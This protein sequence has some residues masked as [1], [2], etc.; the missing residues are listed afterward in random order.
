ME[1]VYDVHRLVGASLGDLWWW[2]LV[3]I[4]SRPSTLFTGFG[5][6]TKQLMTLAGGKVVLVLEGGYVLP[7]LCDTAEMCLRALLHMEVRA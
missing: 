1:F 5:Y 7:A 2:S 3:I 6:M 4:S